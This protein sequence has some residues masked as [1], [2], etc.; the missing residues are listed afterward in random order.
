MVAH[1][2]KLEKTV[3]EAVNEARLVI[4]TR[5]LARLHDLRLVEC[6]EVG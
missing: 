6:V 3:S 1:T 5:K 4:R 2:F